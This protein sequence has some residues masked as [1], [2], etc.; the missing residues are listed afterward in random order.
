VEPFDGLIGFLKNKF[1][2]TFPF[3]PHRVQA[4]AFFDSWFG[5]DVIQFV[6][7]LGIK[8]AVSSA[9]A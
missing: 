1:V 7:G 8:P 4:I 3:T 5:P 6:A 2:H 9:K